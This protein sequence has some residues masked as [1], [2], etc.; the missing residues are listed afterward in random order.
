MISVPFF[1]F[2]FNLVTRKYRVSI[3]RVNTIRHSNDLYL[4]CS[5]HAT[6]F[7]IRLFLEKTRLWTEQFYIFL[8]SYF[9]I[10]LQSFTRVNTSK[11]SN[12][13]VLFN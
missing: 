1:F 13:N 6:D 8:F 3:V 11:S 7:R 4:R 10:T 5:M 9:S 12:F 2:L